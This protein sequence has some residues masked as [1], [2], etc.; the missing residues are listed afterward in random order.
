MGADNTYGET[1]FNPEKMTQL[2]QTYIKKLKDYIKVVDGIIGNWEMSNI[3]LTNLRQEIA[4]LEK[5]IQFEMLCDPDLYEASAN[6]HFEK[7]MQ[8]ER[9]CKTCKWGKCGYG[10]CVWCI[11]E[12]PFNNGRSGYIDNYEP[13][14]D[15]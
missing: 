12:H 4:E 11:H 3:K 13:K 8:T 15:E 14:T 1:D 6:E 10:H 5:Q 2:E 7:Q 9:T